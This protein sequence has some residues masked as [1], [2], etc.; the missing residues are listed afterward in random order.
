M[1]DFI[2]TPRAASLRD[3]E[4]VR[5]S[6]LLAEDNIK[7]KT[8]E[9]RADLLQWRLETTASQ[10]WTNSRLGGNF[11]IN[12][13]PQY[14]RY[15]DIRIKGMALRNH[16]GD[17]EQNLGMGRFHSEQMDDAQQII[18]MQF[19]QPEYN[20]MLSFFT[21]FFDGDAS[22]MASEGRGTI[23]YYLGRAAGLII[24]IATV[25]RFP[26]YILGGFAA[27]YFLG[28]P[29]SKYYYMVPRM[30]LYWNRVNMIANHIAVNMGLVPRVWDTE[31]GAAAKDKTRPEDDPYVQYAYRNARDIFNKDGGIN[32][33]AVANKAQRMADNYY[34][35]L[36]QAAEETGNTESYENPGTIKG[37][38]EK[39]RAVA[40]TP[41]R[42]DGPR[43]FNQYLEEYHDSAIGNMKYRRTDSVTNSD[44]SEHQQ[45]G[46]AEGTETK[47]DN[48]PSN[49]GSLRD[50]YLPTD[51]NDPSEQPGAVSSFFNGIGEALIPGYGKEDGF[52]D[53]WMANRRDGSDYVSFRVNF[54]GT[55]SESFSNG[56]RD[57]DISQKFNGFS[58]TAR[59]ARFTFS[60]GKTG[61]APLDWVTG[62]ATDLF[63]GALDGIH[64]GGLLSLAGSAFVDIPKHWENSTVSLPTTSYTIEL[65]A[66]YGNKLSRFMN[67]YVPLA[68]LLAGTLPISTGKQSYTSP[69][70]CNLFSRGRAHV[71]LGMIESLTI[72]RGAGNMGWNKN[73]EC[74]GIDI[75]ISVV[76]LSSIAH[77]PL[78]T[79]SLNPLKGVFDED[80]MFNDYMAVL[81]NLSLADQTYPLRKL[82]LA[83]TRKREQYDSF[84]SKAHFANAMDN[85]WPTRVAGQVTSF[86]MRATERS[87]GR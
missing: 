30:P 29:S 64:M 78:D 66:P 36:I 1:S 42:D 10:K 14:T 63:A 28:M 44:I 54:E 70:L 19:G 76:D 83:L 32:V 40:S 72:T 85:F 53:Y 39:M 73:N 43:P 82:A 37:M 69:F 34:N 71:R 77:M 47:A 79:G 56:V 46:Q 11:T 75:S 15:S 26:V 80:N 59:S 35:A 4:W 61:I 2:G 60:E 52:F 45:A 67:L 25:V 23:F 51:A 20:G 5:T 8:E 17:L 24:S 13:I 50:K 65:R 41:I 74:L 9:E 84:F 12:T 33:Y 81:G 57:S 86:F 31:D 87:L 38:A 55:V 58:N 49:F 6:F 16:Q 22:I 7:G 68:C 62:A 27:R 18:H 48:K 3:S 21:S